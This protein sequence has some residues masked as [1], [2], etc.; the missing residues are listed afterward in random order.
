MDLAG[1]A[2]LV[3]GQSPGPGGSEKEGSRYPLGLA[4]GGVAAATFSLLPVSRKHRPSCG[5]AGAETA[6]SPAPSQ[7]PLRAT[8]AAPQGPLARR[9]GAAVAASAGSGSFA[10]SAPPTLLQSLGF[11]PFSLTDPDG[12]P[13]LP[14]R[15]G[16]SPCSAACSAFVPGLPS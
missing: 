13:S 9:Q 3:Q 1:S 6:A 8:E 12:G 11:S 5:P 14:G 10:G 15:Q 4:A 16:A 7:R 2:S